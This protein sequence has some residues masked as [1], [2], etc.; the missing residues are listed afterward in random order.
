MENA[1]RPG[2]RD[3]LLFFHA[4]MIAGKMGQTA[5]AKERLQMALRINPQ[6]HVVYAAAAAQQLKALD[7]TEKTAVLSLGAGSHDKN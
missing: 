6:F 7:A 5:L 1:L 4:G 3:A 2:T